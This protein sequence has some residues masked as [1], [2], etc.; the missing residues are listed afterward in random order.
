VSRAPPVPVRSR[1]STFKMISAM[2]MPQ[3]EAAAR[4]ARGDGNLEPLRVERWA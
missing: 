3:N 1:T 4:C 2:A